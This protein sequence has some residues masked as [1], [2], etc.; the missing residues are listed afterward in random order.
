MVTV[1]L[2][3][4]DFYYTVNSKRTLS[5]VRD[6]VNCT[7]ADWLCMLERFHVAITVLVS[8]FL[9]CVIIIAGGTSVR[10]KLRDSD[11]CTHNSYS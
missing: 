10:T 2:Q 4:T 6:S 7:F 9:D 8:L 5:W 11:L 3:L 1:D